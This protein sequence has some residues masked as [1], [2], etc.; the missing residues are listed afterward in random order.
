LDHHDL[1]RGLAALGVVYCHARVLLIQSVSN[2]IRPID[3]VLYLLSGYGHSAVMVF[4][5]LSGYLVGGSVVRATTS[6]RWSWG[7][8]LLARGVRLYLVLVP[9]LLL[10]ALWD[11]IGLEAVSGCPGNDDTARA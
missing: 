11:R 1:I 7:D 5:V 10:T 2:G 9:A 4:F 6:G 3:R 8:Y